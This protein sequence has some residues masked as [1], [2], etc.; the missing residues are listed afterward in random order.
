MKLKSIRSGQTATV[1]SFLKNDLVKFDYQ[2]LKSFLLYTSSTLSIV[3]SGVPVQAEDQLSVFRASQTT[4]L[5]LTTLP[6]LKPF[7]ENYTTTSVTANTHVNL[8]VIVL[9]ELG[10]VP[11]GSSLVELDKPVPTSSPNQTSSLLAELPIEAT[12]AGLLLNH[13]VQADTSAA[14][15]SEPFSRPQPPESRFSGSSSESETPASTPPSSEP[16]SSRRTGNRWQFTVEPYFFVPLSVRGDVTAA[17]RSA[18]IDLGLGDILNFDHA[19]DAGLR[20]EAQHNRLGFILDAF[21]ISA[22]QSG[23]VGVTFPQGSLQ[24]FGISTAAR[25]D[26]DASISIREVTIDAAISYRVIDTILGHS[27]A[28]SSPYPRLV[29]APILG[30]RSKFLREN[31][32]VDTVRIGG[33]SLPVDRNFRA[34][35][36]TVE[37]LIG[38][39]I[40]LDLSDR[41]ALNVR[42]DVSGFNINADQDYTWNLLVGAQYKLSQNISLQLA[43]RF[44][45]SDFEDGDGLRRIRLNLYQ[46]GIWLSGIFRF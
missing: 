4:S 37:P 34:S 22:G 32:E 26:A 44:N 36:T 18:S 33:F 29:I 13:A 21:Y 28:S 12:E 46:N 25:L 38:T 2:L 31:L 10:Q 1:E 27:T 19:F 43:Y 24:R 17:G 45:G 41:W 40:D 7:S 5:Q 14:Q 30:L 11:S 20:L 16:S 8:G 42:G 9:K 15:P 6:D 3:L 23:T 35:R 39:Q